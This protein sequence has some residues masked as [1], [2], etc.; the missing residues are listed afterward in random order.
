MWQLSR[1]RCEGGGWGG[2]R[3][4]LRSFGVRS[5]AR[6]GHCLLLDQARAEGGEKSECLQ[7]WWA[8]QLAAGCLGLEDVS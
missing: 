2:R 5:G 3:L 1:G 4:T 6:A 7:S 8:P